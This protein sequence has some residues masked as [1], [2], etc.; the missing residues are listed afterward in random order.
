MPLGSTAGTSCL[1]LLAPHGAPRA[2]GAVPKQRACGSQAQ[3]VAWRRR[4]EWYPLVN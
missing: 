1:A 2:A 4:A 3:V